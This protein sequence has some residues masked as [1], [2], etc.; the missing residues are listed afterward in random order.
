MPLASKLAFYFE[1]RVQFKGIGLFQARRVDV[2][3]YSPGQFDAIVHGGSDYVVGLHFADKRLRISCQCQYFDQNGECKHL[4]AAVLEADRIGA[5]SL[6]AAE[7]DLRVDE[8][9][10]DQPRDVR[11]PVRV[12]QRALQSQIPA[13]EEHLTAIRHGLEQRRP[14]T[15]WPRDFQVLY[16]LDLGSSKTAGHLVVELLS[17]TRKKSGEWGAIKELRVNASTVGLLP[18]PTDVEAITLVLGGQTSSLYSYESSYGATSKALPPALALKLLPMLDA[19]GR[20]YSRPASYSTDLSPLRWDGGEPWRFTLEVRQD[21]R[22]QWNITGSLRRGEQRMDLDAPALLLADGFLV[23]ND[24]VVR[25][26]AGGGFAWLDQL[27]R[28]KRIPFPDRER[29]KVIASLLSLPVVPPLEIDEPLRFEQ[30]EGKPRFGLKI[31]QHKNAWGEEFFEGRLLTDYGRGWEEYGGGSRGMWLPK[32]RVYV[33]R[34]PLA[35]TGARLTLD[36]E[37]LKP[38]EGRPGA[39]RLPVRAMPRAATASSSSHPRP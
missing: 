24:S 2:I 36:A 29:D 34:D 20:L 9:Y 6:A 14:A 27:R 18:D 25:F 4:W 7:P 28:V 39:F 23:A 21:D 15:A 30:R 31:T 26:D 12:P 17:Q 5:L 35:E 1:K 19:T 13:W 16:A 10:G 8:D 22:D 33:L 3:S 38:L 37:G 11:T 32:E